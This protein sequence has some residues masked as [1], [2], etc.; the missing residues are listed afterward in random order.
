MRPASFNEGNSE[1]A[2]GVDSDPPYPW[3]PPEVARAAA[4]ECLH[5]LGMSPPAS[6]ASVGRK[7][8]AAIAM[9][10]A[11]LASPGLLRRIVMARTAH[12]AGNDGEP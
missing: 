10:A 9:R 12:R 5:L 11:H 3:L 1:T 2:A 6:A 8:A 7:E 4:A